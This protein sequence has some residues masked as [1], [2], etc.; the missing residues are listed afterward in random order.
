MWLED[1]AILQWRIGVPKPKPEVGPGSAKLPVEHGAHQ[2]ARGQENDDPSK[3]RNLGK[4]GKSPLVEGCS[5]RSNLSV[6][7]TLRHNALQ[8][9]S[10]TP[11]M[12]SW[13]GWFWCAMQLG[14]K[15]TRKTRTGEIYFYS[16]KFQTAKSTVNKSTIIKAKNLRWLIKWR[17]V[18]FL[19][20]FR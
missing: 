2:D 19:D 12:M 14:W 13:E 3:R 11:C 10:T 5:L 9:D 8:S 16:G 4:H 6:L 20:T 17:Q 18:L 7:Q 1:A 15:N